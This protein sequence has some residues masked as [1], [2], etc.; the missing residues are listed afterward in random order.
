VTFSVFTFARTS[1]KVEA[2]EMRT[3]GFAAIAAAGVVAVSV[4]L[5]APAMADGWD[6]FPVNSGN[7]TSVNTG[8][9]DGGPQGTPLPSSAGSEMSFNGGPAD[10][11][12]MTSP[13]ANPYVPIG[14]GH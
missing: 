4:G 1:E 12:P 3:V 10:E 6:S 8:Y 5:A 2:G 14:V 11:F 7:D 13:G 9:R